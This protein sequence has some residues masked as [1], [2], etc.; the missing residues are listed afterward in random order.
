MGLNTW[1]NRG[2]WLDSSNMVLLNRYG[3]IILWNG[4]SHSNWVVRPIFTVMWNMECWEIG[5]MKRHPASNF[6]NSHMGLCCTSPW[7][8]TDVR[9][10][11]GLKDCQALKGFVY[12]SFC[13]HRPED[14][15]NIKLEHL[16]YKQLLILVLEDKQT[17]R[18]WSAALW[19]L[20]FCTLSTNFFCNGKTKQNLKKVNIYSAK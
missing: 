12:K 15:I 20:F 8:W 11:F 3:H 5:D 9:V 14:L 7:W 10:K 6:W 1:P 16:W 19:Q 4:C 2:K 17:D 13:Q 18:F